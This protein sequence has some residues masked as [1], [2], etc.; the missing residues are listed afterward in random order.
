[1]Y[2]KVS[3]NFDYTQTNKNGLNLF[4]RCYRLFKYIEKG[5]S[6]SKKDLA[7]KKTVKLLNL[8]INILKHSGSISRSSDCTGT[9]YHCSSY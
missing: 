9:L 1:M 7:V 4:L 3:K 2:S 8:R 6:T 5:N